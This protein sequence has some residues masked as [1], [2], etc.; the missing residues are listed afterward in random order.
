MCTRQRSRPTVGR[1]RDAAGEE[2]ELRLEGMGPSC[3]AVQE[4]P[5]SATVFFEAYST[6]RESAGP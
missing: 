4:G 1:T 3:L 5:V 2:H 6:S